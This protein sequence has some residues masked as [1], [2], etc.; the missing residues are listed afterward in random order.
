MIRYALLLAILSTPPAFAEDS[1]F[2]VSMGGQKLGRV[3]Y[4]GQS[5]GKGQAQI[6]AVFNNTPLGVFDGTYDASSRPVGNKGEVNYRGLSKSSGKTR[7]VS[8][9]SNAK[10]RAIAVTISPDK[11]KTAFSNLANVTVEGL[12]NPVLTFGRLATSTTCPKAFKIYDARRIIQVTPR[13]SKK[14]DDV[15]TCNLDYTVV[16]GPGH[17]SPFRFTSLK[18]TLTYDPTR[19][20]TGPSRF[21][22]RVGIFEV[23]FSR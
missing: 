22:L 16:A 14:V 3:I 15:L 13:A 21:T 4:S 18:L 20:K 12:L 2:D 6:R 5:D 10:G 23:T 8:I 9:T 7:D 1:S 11:D 19:I 17:L